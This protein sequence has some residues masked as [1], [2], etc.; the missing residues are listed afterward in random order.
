MGRVSQSENPGKMAYCAG[1][2]SVMMRRFCCSVK[3]PGWLAVAALAGAARDEVACGRSEC[4][5]SDADRICSVVREVARA[6]IVNATAY[7]AVDQAESSRAGGRINAVAPGILAEEGKRLGHCCCT[8]RPTTF[9][10][11]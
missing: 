7:T 5:L 10:T 2:L 9:T 11:D 4:D 6:I 3:W 1:F 8:I